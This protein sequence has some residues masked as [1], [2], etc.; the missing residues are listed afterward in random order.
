M[1]ARAAVESQDMLHNKILQENPVHARQ[2]LQSLCLH[3]PGLFRLPTMDWGI[4]HTAAFC[5]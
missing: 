2:S 5:P 3:L 1:H 4:L